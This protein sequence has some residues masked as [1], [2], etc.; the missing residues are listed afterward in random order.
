MNCFLYKDNKLHCENVSVEDVCKKIKT[1]FYLYSSKQIVNNYKSLSDRLRSCNVLIAY[2][3]KANSNI[4]VLRLLAKK[5]AGADVVSYGELVRAIKAGIPGRKIVFSGV[6]KSD[7]EISKAIDHKILQFNVESSHE[8]LTIEKIARDKGITAN[9]SIRVNPDIVAGGHPKIS[10]GKKTDKFGISVNE[11]AKV[12]KDAAN[13]KYLKIVGVDMHIGSQILD[14]KPFKNS[15]KKIE[16]FTYTLKNLKVNI[17]NI[18]L[19]GGLGIN[20]ARMKRSDITKEYTALIK[21]IYNKTRK[22]IIIEPGRFI[23]AN[24]GILVTKILYKKKN[25]NKNF[26]IVDAGMN[27]FLRPALYD[28]KHNIKKLHSNACEDSVEDFDIVGPICETADVLVERANLFSKV[29]RGD[30][31]FIDNVGAYGAVMS[32]TYNSRDLIAEVLVNK[33]KFC[34]VRKKMSSENFIKLEKIPNWLK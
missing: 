15:F 25:D 10:T 7:L 21:E 18:D 24:A 5:G 22:K 2:A 26:L 20:Y 13:L 4:S 14:I 9:I 12:Y 32:S 11:A 16:K 3:V 8:L 19:G 33:D 27:D 23:V 28:A 29:D 1:P 34:L 6:G 17:K 30:Y 31:L